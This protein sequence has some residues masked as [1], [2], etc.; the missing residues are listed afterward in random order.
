MAVT[1]I[2]LVIM[3]IQYSKFMM[4]HYNVI[5]IDRTRNPVLEPESNDTD[6]DSL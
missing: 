3:K 6:C 2:L 1:I 5:E 4:T